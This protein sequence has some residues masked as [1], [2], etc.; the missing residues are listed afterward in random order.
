MPLLF[1]RQHPLILATAVV[2]LA[3]LGAGTWRYRQTEKLIL[4]ELIVNAQRCSL[5]FNPP[6]L[7][8]FSGTAADAQLPNY[9]AIKDRL[10]RLAAVDANTRSIQLVR[11]NSGTHQTAILLSSDG[12]STDVQKP[13]AT[14]DF[15]SSQLWTTISTGRPIAEGPV[16]SNGDI[17]ITGY[18]SIGST[19]AGEVDIVALQ[20]SARHWRSTL[21]NAAIGTAVYVWMFLILPLTALVTT[22]RQTQQRDALRNLTEAMEQGQSAVMIVN[23]DRRIEYANAGLCRQIGYQRRELIGREWMDFQRPGTPENLRADLVKTVRSGVPWAGE[24]TM[25][26]KDGSTFPARGTVTPV[27]DRGGEIRSFV[28][29]F[30]DITEIRRTESVLLE[31]KERAEAG[32]RAKGQFL[33][34]MSHEVRTPLN[35]IVGF[36][37]LLLDTELTPEQQEFV[38]TIRTSSE[39]LIQLTGDILDYARIES[40]R[41]KL[42]PQPCDARECVENALDLAAAAAVQKNIELLHWTEENVPAAIVADVSRLRQVLVNLVNNAVKFTMNGEV[43]VGVR[44]IDHAD[45]S[46]GEPGLCVLEFSVKDS[47]IGIAPEHHRKI[48]RPFSQVDDSTTRRFGGTGL[49]LA[50]CKNI[51]E[52]M[53]GKISFVSVPGRGSTFTFTV[54]VGIHQSDELNLSR[55]PSPL[56]NQRLAVASESPGLSAELSR[57]GQRLGAEVIQTTPRDVATLPGWDLAIVDV[58][59][60]RAMEFASLRGP[61]PNLPPERMIAV[62]PILLPGE[63]RAALRTHFR[64]VLNKPLH[65]EMLANL[66]AAPPPAP[67]AGQLA[68]TGVLNFQ[69]LIVEDNP[70]NQQLTQKMLQNLGCRWTAVPNGRIALER[71]QQV[72]PDV[73]LM[74]LHMPE[75]DGLS[76][77]TKIRAGDA[78]AALHDV[79]IIALTADARGE[80]RERTLAAGANDYLTKPV[81]IPDLAAALNR[82]VAAR[83]T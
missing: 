69:V 14:R 36:A 63:L 27:K 17:W 11:G 77:I 18:A 49:G 41:L 38:E 83:R 61:L 51:V 33:A 76:A 68:Q 29:V 62:V 60:T 73:V 56:A 2:F 79:W 47:G 39:T 48:F 26:R 58:N 32:D 72:N 43:Q 40:G 82:F 65:H 35:G 57:L 80:Q 70:V 4:S 50:I 19:P 67:R 64:I 66:L 23:L 81:Q 45:P 55:S 75:L 37:S 6:E 21:W 16:A 13:G 7:A 44:R 5:A 74:D 10:D 28:T 46:P 42:E 78:G 53:D 31:A 34:T 30:E 24:W 52:L 59:G 71:L 1:K 3:G 8:A 22:R 15:A 9:T 20:L 54:K 25:Q 12:R